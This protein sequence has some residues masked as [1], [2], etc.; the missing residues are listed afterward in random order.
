ME[1]VQ[2][3]QHSFFTKARRSTTHTK[4]FKQKSFVRIVFFVSS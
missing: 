4:S 2:K 3:S 1:V